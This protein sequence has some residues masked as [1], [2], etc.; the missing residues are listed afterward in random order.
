MNSFLQ[1][2]KSNAN[3]TLT[4]NGAITHK[5]TG[6]KV[7]DMFAEGGAYR[8][9]TKEDLLPFKFGAVSIAK[10]TNSLEFVSIGYVMNIQK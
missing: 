3:Y 10:K 1:T 4:E 6:S 8:N 7:Y 5:T 2:M 9:R